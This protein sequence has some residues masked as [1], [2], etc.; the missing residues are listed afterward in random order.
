MQVLNTYYESIFSTQGI[1]ACIC[2]CAALLIFGALAISFLEIGNSW[3]ELFA[4]L[5]VG[6]LILVALTVNHV[7]PFDHKE[8]PHYEI[9][10]EDDYPVSQLMEQYEITE[11]KGEIL[12]CIDKEQ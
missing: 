7:L 11:V 4:A 10:V 12:D 5:A 8:K 2:G 6:G 3:G 1:I 9:I